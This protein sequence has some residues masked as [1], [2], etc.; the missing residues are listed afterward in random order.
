M[1]PSAPAATAALRAAACTEFQLALRPHQLHAAPDRCRPLSLQ[2]TVELAEIGGSDTYLH[3]ETA[4][5]TVVAQWPGIHPLPLGSPVALFLDP[6]ECFGFSAA[7]ETLFV[8]AGG[9]SRGDT[10]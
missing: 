3:I 8:P 4:G 6:Q 1:S 10:D 9:G 2:G 5:T 7:G